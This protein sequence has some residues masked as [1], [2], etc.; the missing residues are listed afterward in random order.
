LEDATRR[1]LKRLGQDI[2][3]FETLLAASL[4]IR[5]TSRL[6]NS[7][8]HGLGGQRK[9]ATILNGVLTVHRNDGW[10]DEQGEERVHVLGMM[11]TDAV[12]GAFSSNDL[13][14]QCVR[15]WGALLEP[16]VPEAKPWVERV[17]P[18]P[19]G[20]VVKVSAGTKPVVPLGAT[21]VFDIPEQLRNLLAAEAKNRSESA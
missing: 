9:N 11:V 7:W 15:D 16:L 8:K 4:A 10:R 1:L 13:F 12:E 19:K 18:G 20:A 14:V 3:S 6:V 2:N 21:V 5:V 17:V